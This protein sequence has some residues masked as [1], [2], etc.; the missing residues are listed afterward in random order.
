MTEYL[1][2]LKPIIT[3]QQYERTKNIVK[4]FS[5]HP[6]PKLHEYLVNKREEEDN[7]VSLNNFKVYF[8][9]KFVKIY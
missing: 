7:W 2:A 9:F 5:T 6:G 3:P 4:Q 1:R 8:N